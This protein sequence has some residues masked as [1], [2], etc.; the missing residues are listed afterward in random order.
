MVFLISEVI[1]GTW[2]FS[3]P[4]CT[5][6]LIFDSLNKF[7]APIIALLISRTCYA[8]VCLN[9]KYQ[10]RAANLKFAFLQVVFCLVL[11]M[12]VLWPVFTYSG[13]DTLF[14]NANHTEKSVFT[15]HKCNFQPPPKIQLGF[16][17]IACIAN[18]AIPLAG[19]LYWYLS[20]PYFLRR[21]AETTL[22]GK[23]GLSE[24]A[25]RK[26]ITTALVLTF[27]YVACWSPYWIN[28]FAHQFTTT[29]LRK[30]SYPL[31][32]TGMNRAIKHAHAQLILN[33]RRKLRSFT[34]GATRQV[35]QKLGIFHKQD[36]SASPFI[37]TPTPSVL[38]QYKI[39]RIFHKQDRSASPFIPTPTP[40]VQNAHLQPTS[41]STNLNLITSPSLQS[42]NTTGETELEEMKRE[43]AENIILNPIHAEI[44][45]DHPSEITLE[46]DASEV[47]L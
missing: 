1:L 40:S 44:E 42:V 27:V 17:I 25:I 30:P 43:L 32:F 23:S 37:P 19:I 29:G 15:I 33:Q 2:T 35:R 45:K 36:R 9:P 3:A 20:V 21:R 11:V 10:E 47:L 24:T 38:L 8:S 22:V 4:A 46:N 34:D 7:M 41:V 18:Y 26:V 16:S 39:F 13:V 28:L 5:T 6:Y 14:F 31:I 12:I